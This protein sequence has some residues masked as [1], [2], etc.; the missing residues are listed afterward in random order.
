MTDRN[1]LV[2][3]GSSG[4]GLATSRTI[5]HGGDRV[6]MVSSST[7]KLA[8][9]LASLDYEEDHLSF[10][11]NLKEMENV[12]SIFDFLSDGHI[13]LDGMIYCAGVSPKQLVKDFDYRIAEDTYRIN[14]LAF[15]ECVKQSLRT[16]SLKE[17][18][19]IVAVG[20]VTA[21]AAGFNQVIYGSSKAALAAAVKLMAPELLNNHHVNINCISP[22][23][24]DTEMLHSVYSNTENYADRVRHIQPLGPIPAESVARAIVF[25]LSDSANHITGSDMQFDG[26]FFL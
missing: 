24:T 6:I 18:A 23:C 2:I 13:K 4:I 3:G 11:C 19:K 10:C 5:A 12:G 14:V 7:A 9:A 17:G 20:S 21:K 15:I 22:G 1:Y 16:N 25:L 26:G 8:T